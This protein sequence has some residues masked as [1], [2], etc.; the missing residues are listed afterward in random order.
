M[1]KK[2]WMPLH[3]RYLRRYYPFHST[4][5]LA[6]TLQ[7][8]LYAVTMRSYRLG[9]EK[10]KISRYNLWPELHDRYVRR[11]YAYGDTNVMAKKLNRHPHTLRARAQLMGVKK[12]ERSNRKPVADKI[13]LPAVKKMRVKEL[14]M[15]APVVKKYIPKHSDKYFPDND[16]SVKLKALEGVEIVFEGRLFYVQEVYYMNCRYII[17]TDRRAF[18]KDV[19]QMQDMLNAIEIKKSA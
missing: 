4:K 6:K 5:L 19:Y 8:S 9:L 10:K 15:T 1:G 17:Q 16:F 11:Y 12:M 3:D 13:K 2:V 7:R 18:V 14:I